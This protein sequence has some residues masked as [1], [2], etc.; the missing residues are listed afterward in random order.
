MRCAPPL[1]A[2]GRCLRAA[3]EL[4]A[5]PHFPKGPADATQERGTCCCHC[6]NV[7]SMSL[8][9][10]PPRSVARARRLPRARVRRARC[11]HVRAAVSMAARGGRCVLAARAALRRCSP[12]VPPGD[13]APRAR[14][15]A[16]AASQPRAAAAAAA[17]AQPLPSTT[18]RARTLSPRRSRTLGALAVASAAAVVALQ[19]DA[20]RR[21]ASDAAE[22]ASAAAALAR[23]V[24]AEAA[25]A[26]AAAAPEGAGA[27]PAAPRAPCVPRG[28][29]R[30]GC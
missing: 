1:R 15:C 28:C 7:R 25:A 27:C 17:A 24:Y 8:P 19:A 14:A 29:V 22:A 18:E 11:V 16:S 9:Q 13:A 4:A 3:C 6:N 2:A 23:A 21:G 5:L 26:A 20:V 30:G 12:L 10:R